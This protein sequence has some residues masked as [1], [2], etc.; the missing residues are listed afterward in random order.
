VSRLTHEE[1]AIGVSVEGYAHVTGLANYDV[2]EFRSILRLYW[3]GRV[4]GESTIQVEIERY[5]LT[6]EMLEHGRYNH[7][8]HSIAGIHGD[9]IGSNFTYVNEREDV[10]DIGSG[11][12]SLGDVSLALSLRES[13]SKGEVTNLEQAGIR[14]ESYCISTAHL[15][16]VV[17]GRI[18][19]RGNHNTGHIRKLADREIELVGSGKAEIYGIGSLMG[20]SSHDRFGE[21]RGRYSH[22][23]ANCDFG[24]G[25]ELHH[26]ATDGICGSF[27][28]CFWVDTADIIRPKDL[29]VQLGRLLHAPLLSPGLQL[30]P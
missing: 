14:T 17:P 20:Y 15:H 23:T 19:R 9:T 10:L 1:H 26:R 25:E 2:A 12:V 6:R 4:V 7:A 30:T 29:W 5:Q 21:C 8:G 16:A 22:V 13:T 11:D 3:A 24:S 27:V 18:V 28:K